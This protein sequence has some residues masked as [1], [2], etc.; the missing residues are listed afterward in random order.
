MTGTRR[1]AATD[2]EAL[3]D[4]YIQSLRLVRKRELSQFRRER[5]DEDAISNAALALIEGAKHPH[6]YR[7]PPA[8]LQESRR[9]L[10]KNLSLIRSTTSFQE[11]IELVR[12]ARAV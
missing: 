1:R 11:L 3:V 2:L 7:N 5:T 6:Q 12:E 9:R 4:D 8:S 10:L